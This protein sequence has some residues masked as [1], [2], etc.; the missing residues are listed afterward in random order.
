M[1]DQRDS[2]PYHATSPE[3]VN[4]NKTVFEGG[5]FESQLKDAPPDGVRES[6][7]VGTALCPE[8]GYRIRANDTSCPHCGQAFEANG[9]RCSSCKAQIPLTA[10]FCPSCGSPSDHKKAKP[11]TINPW[12]AA[13]HST[14]TLIPLPRENEKIDLSPLPFSGNEV[15]LNRDNTEPGNQSITSKEQAALR[16]ENNSWHIEDRSAMK[17]TF[18]QAGEKKRLKSGDVLL[19]GNRRFVFND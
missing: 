13:D 17:T 6:S 7:R 8:C 18:I 5:V 11:G 12:E 1:T 15:I 9:V 4:L 3:N 14:C 2:R 10:N 19:L 16:Y